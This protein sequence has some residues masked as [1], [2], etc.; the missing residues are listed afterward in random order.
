MPVVRWLA[1][2]GS[3]IGLR[4]PNA[5]ERARAMGME[6]YIQGIAL[7]DRAI[8]DAQGG[9]SDRCF[10]GARCGRALTNWV[11]GGALAAHAF[12]SPASVIATYS[13][14]LA[15]VRECAEAAGAPLVDHPVPSALRG[16][17]LPIPRTEVPYAAEHGR[18]AR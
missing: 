16:Q 3:S 4:V 1:T 2:Q 10:L 18:G 15:R 12:P 13:R 8:F 9:A 17:L 6:A 14:L 5:R 11:T 7:S